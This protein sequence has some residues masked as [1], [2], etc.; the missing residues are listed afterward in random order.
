MTKRAE[1][2]VSDRAFDP[3]VGDKARG[4]ADALGAIDAR[5]GVGGAATSCWP[6]AYRMPWYRTWSETMH[7]SMSEGG[8]WFLEAGGG[9]A[10]VWQ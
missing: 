1:G 5:V 2:A 3:S 8:I 10:A 7:G 9:G 6:E 4:C